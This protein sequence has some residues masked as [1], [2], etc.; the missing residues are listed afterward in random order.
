MA[1]HTAIA[2]TSLGLHD[3]CI[4]INAGAGAS[5]QD[6]MTSSRAVPAKPEAEAAGR[7][8]WGP[9]P[10]RKTS[11]RPTART[12]WGRRL[13]CLHTLHACIQHTRYVTRMLAE[14]LMP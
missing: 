12:L 2:D 14:N 11:I 6:E 10:L 9:L 5:T 3:Q 1:L 13:L 8:R 7:Q 4:S